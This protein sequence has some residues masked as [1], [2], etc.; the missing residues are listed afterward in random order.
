V[1][2]NGI[3]KVDEFAKKQSNLR[4]IC[5]SWEL[6]TMNA[7]WQNRV[8]LN[9]TFPSAGYNSLHDAYIFDVG[10]SHRLA[11]NVFF[12]AKTLPIGIVNVIAVMDHTTYE[13]WSN[14]KE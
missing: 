3:D 9:Q 12:V 1:L 5:K 13:K 4:N 14:K 7:S 2:I 11:A 8:E 10:K 6:R